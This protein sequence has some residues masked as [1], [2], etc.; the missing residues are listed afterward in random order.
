MKFAELVK[1]GIKFCITGGLNTL[2]D[3]AVTNAL[4]VLL[5][6]N[7][8]IAKPIGYLLGMVNS[9]VVNKKWTFKTENKHTMKEIIKFAIVNLCMLGLSLVLIKAFKDFFMLG[10]FW[11]NIFATGIVVVINFFVSNF[12]VFKGQK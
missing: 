1:K 10:D 7:I 6:V 4:N 8:Y 12:W 5:S 3:L 9:F 2:I 11:S